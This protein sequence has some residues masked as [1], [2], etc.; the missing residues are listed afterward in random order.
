MGKKKDITPRKK[1]KVEL[2]LK[3]KKFSN[4]A[5]AREI[6]V[7][8]PYVS[9]LSKKILKNIRISPKRKGACGRKRK[10]TESTKRLIIRK[11][12]QSRTKT[13]AEIATELKHGGTNV[14][15]RTVRRCLFDSGLPARKPR[16][17]QKLTLK[18]KEKRFLWAKQYL[19]WT[20]DDWN[21]VKIL[22]LHH[23]INNIHKNYIARL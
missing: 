20:N 5:I 13:S 18:M 16:L 3:M 21:K 14:S 11:V 9:V 10:L 1:A 19:N 8:R 12:I 23:L 22:Y 15:D 4:A 7:S 2:M 17:K 6:G